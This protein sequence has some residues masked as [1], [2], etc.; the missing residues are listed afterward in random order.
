[1]LGLGLISWLFAYC[2][3]KYM[4]RRKQLELEPDII[5][6]R[7]YNERIFRR[8][9]KRGTCPEGNCLDICDARFGHPE[10]S[11]NGFDRYFN[12][13][14]RSQ[15]AVKQTAK[16]KQRASKIE[17]LYWEVIER[18]SLYI[19]CIGIVFIQ[20]WGF[21]FWINPINFR[22]FRHSLMISGLEQYSLDSRG[23]VL[24]C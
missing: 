16:V 12:K 19:R 24:W 22:I 3:H 11:S 7:V 18:F 17:F 13:T 1:M 21:I 23:S 15:K 9:Q 2:G 14:I 10:W 5:S 4:E 6:I 8:W 20:M